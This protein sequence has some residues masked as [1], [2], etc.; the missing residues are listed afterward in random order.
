VWIF[1]IF[2]TSKIC[3]SSTGVFSNLFPPRCRLSS[4]RRHHAAAQCHASFPWRQ[5]ELVASTSSF[6]NTS[7]CR[8]LISSRNRNIKSVPLPP[9]TPTST[10]HYYKN[11]ISNLI[12]LF[13]TQSCLYFVFS[14][15]RAPLHRS[16]TRCHHPHLPSSHTH[17][18]SAQQHP[19]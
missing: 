16:S 17:H 3:V 14:L 2:Q 12:T 10:L 6:D 7:F 8:L 9:A 13:T 5:D 1:F 11:V 19:W 15:A 4:D 18:L